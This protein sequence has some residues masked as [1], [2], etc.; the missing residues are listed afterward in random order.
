M[1][2]GSC[3]FWPH[4]S[5]EVSRRQRRESSGAESER[6]RLAG[7][8]DGGVA[9]RVVRGFAGSTAQ[10]FVSRRSPQRVVET[11]VA[12]Q[13]ARQQGPSSGQGDDTRQRKSRQPEQESAAANDRRDD[14]LSLT[15][16]DRLI[17]H[18]RQGRVSSGHDSAP[19]CWAGNSSW[20][21]ANSA[22]TVL[23]E[24]IPYPHALLCFQPRGR[25]RYDAGSKLACSAGGEQR[26][27]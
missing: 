6:R 22:L 4:F 26:G 3:G 15:D 8:G 16:V 11:A 9:D 1:S 21:P 13:S 24:H 5:A 19:D 23:E 25:R 12:G 7:G 17:A 20:K 18:F 14:S 10:A 2:A 27:R